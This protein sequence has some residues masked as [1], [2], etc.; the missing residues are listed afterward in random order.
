MKIALVGN[1]NS[2]KTTFFNELTGSTQY[3]GNWPG[4]TVDKVEGRVKGNKDIVIV[5]L[6]GIYSLSPFSPEE[7]AS[8]LC[9]TD[10]DVNV[11]INIVDATNLER[12]LYLTKQLLEMNKSMVVA[13]NVIDIIEKRGI[14]IDVDKLSDY[15]GCKVIEVSCVI[16]EKNLSSDSKINVSPFRGLNRVLEAALDAVKKGEITHG[17]P[18]DAA[19]ENSISNL[20]NIIKE[21]GILKKY[22]PRWAAIKLLENDKILFEETKNLNILTEKANYER[23]YL[24]NKF[25]DDSDCLICDG[26]YQQIGNIIK[27]ILVKKENQVSSISDKID[28]VLTNKWLALPIFAFFMWLMYFV[29]M[30]WI[31]DMT[32]GGIEFLVEGLA[33]LAG[34]YL[35]SL[36]ASDWVVGLVVDG[37]IGGVGAV[38][39]FVPQLMI[40]FLFIAILEASGYM[41]RVAFIMDRIFRSFGLSGKSFIPMLIG[42]GCSV[43]AIMATRTIEHKKDRELTIL[44]TPFIPCGAKL[45][46]F[47]L[48][49]AAIFGGNAFYATSMYFL[50]IGIVIVSGFLL[51][52]TKIFGGEVAPFVMELPEYKMPKIKN[53]LLQMWDRGKHFIYKAGTIIFIACGVVWMLQSFDFSFRYIEDMEDSILAAFGNFFAPLFAPL[54]FGNWQSVVATGTGLIAKEVV[55]GTFGVLAGVG[56]AVGEEP[57][58]VQYLNG[59]FPNVAAAYAFMCFTLFAPPCFAAI[60]AMKSEFKS[61][62]MTAFA[63]GFQLLVAYIVS[64][65]VYNIGTIIFSN[66]DATVFMYI[67]L[68]LVVCALIGFTYLVIKH[69]R[70]KLKAV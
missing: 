47:A 17:I 51:K 52:K 69:K 60:G 53:V 61:K 66:K 62:K 10:D 56:E 49:T 16:K 55:V 13:L 70:K 19:I 22:P 65:I 7:I 44:L 21:Q 40:L 9:L 18:F 5:D 36:S 45:P 50:G 33:S 6:P 37:L 24:K 63:I 38:I 26:R 34:G 11:I 35:E 15:L 25:E 43:P 68:A 42:T 27:E 46:V 2:G 30:Q 57:Q 23:E 58:L 39:V 54:G 3:V 8:R 41:S 32:I 12:S 4:V 31:G 29:S 20:I 59:L 14:K 67:V 28:K 64:M 1:P 48:F